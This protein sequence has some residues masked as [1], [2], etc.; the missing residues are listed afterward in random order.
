MLFRSA[1]DHRLALSE[2]EILDRLYAE[3]GLAAETAADPDAVGDLNYVFDTPRLRAV[4]LM[5]LLTVAHADGRV[6]PAENEA[7]RDLADRM[8]LDAATLDRLQAWAYRY[9]GLM[10]EGAAFGREDG[11]A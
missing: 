7:L 8:D 4:A 11:G 2:V 5:N 10:R 9:A 6:D 3:A 1:A